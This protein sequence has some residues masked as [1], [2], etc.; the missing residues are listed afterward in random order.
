MGIDKGIRPAA[1]AKFRELLPQRAE[2]GNT[3]F[4]KAVMA[5]LCDQFGISIAS[6]ATAYNEAFKYVKSIDI[7]LVDRL[8]RP[9]DKKG[10][11]KRKQIVEATAATC[12]LTPDLG[13]QQT[14]FTVKKKIDGSVVSEG[15]SLQQARVLVEKAAAQK[16]AKL[17]WV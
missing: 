6:A 5:F 2:L 8:G 17:Y 7:T 3:G 14:M 13:E 16:K 15:L 12:E 1:R 9:Q 10:G 11:R 4:R